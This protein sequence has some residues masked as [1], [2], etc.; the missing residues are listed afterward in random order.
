MCVCVCM[1][2]G[3]GMN[4]KAYW[5]VYWSKFYLSWRRF[6][7]VEVMLLSLHDKPL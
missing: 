7:G 5:P 2:W 3:R 4:A 6:E 1:V